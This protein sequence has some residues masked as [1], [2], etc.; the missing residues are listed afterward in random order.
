MGVGSGQKKK[1]TITRCVRET[2]GDTTV[3]GDKFEAMVNPQGFT[4]KDSIQ[5]N[6]NKAI[7]ATSQEKIFSRM[8]T[9]SISFKKILLDGTG[10]IDPFGPGVSERIETLKKIVYNYNGQKHE[11]NRVQLLWGNLIFLGRLTSLD[12]NCTMFT[13]NGVPLRAELSMDFEDATS[14]KE[15]QL[16]AN[17]SSPDLTHLVEVRAGDTLPLL[18]HR[19]YGD[20]S[21]YREVAAINNL[22]GLLSL[23]PGT[24]LKFPPLG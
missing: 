15:A 4:R 11:P 16:S 6:E 10:V 14:T 21:Y 23:T 5:Y 7:G 8:G 1:L 3:T 22:P 19:I 13:P 24:Q 9:S 20:C 18:C 12:V 2:N 17:Q